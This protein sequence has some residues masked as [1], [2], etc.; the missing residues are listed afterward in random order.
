MTSQLALQQHTSRTPITP[1]PVDEQQQRQQQLHPQ[2]SSAPQQQPTTPPSGRAPDTSSPPPPQAAAGRMNPFPAVL[3]LDSFWSVSLPFDTDMALADDY[4]RF[5][6]GIRFERVLEDLDAFA[7]N[8]A[9]LHVKQGTR[10]LDAATARNLP[11]LQIV[12]ASVDG[13]VMNPRMRFPMHQHLAMQGCVTWTGTSSAEVFIEMRI[14]RDPAQWAS[15][16]LE[17][18]MR[19]IG[20]DAEADNRDVILNAFF[21]MVARNAS[22]QKAACV[23]PIDVASLGEQDLFRFRRGAESAVRRKREAASS[24]Q[25]TPPTPDEILLMHELLIADNGVGGTSSL[26]SA[27]ALGSVERAHRMSLSGD[28]PAV[29]TATQPGDATTSSAAASVRPKLV[30]MGDTE[31]SSLAMTQPQDR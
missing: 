15:L 14:V 16:S 21:L 31:M 30:A 12:T 24:L 9:H 6:G 10:K 27:S 8:V 23:P 4:M 26:L 7:G 22:T 17:E 20:R 18:K 25:R 11:E 28:T 2:P 29:A 3:P 5:D 19:T 13:I 1:T